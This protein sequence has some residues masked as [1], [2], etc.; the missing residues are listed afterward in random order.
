MQARVHA[1]PD[2]SEAVAGGRGGAASSIA[3]M[4]VHAVGMR[5]GSNGARAR[6]HAQVERARARER[7]RE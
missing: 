2:R 1:A 4:R 7:A 5:S 3:C 6:M